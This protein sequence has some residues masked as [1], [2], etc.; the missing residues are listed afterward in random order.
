MIEMHL[1]G[2]VFLSTGDKQNKSKQKK[3][4]EKQLL[5]HSY[6][7][8]TFSKNFCSLYPI[9]KKDNQ[10][11]LLALKYLKKLIYHKSMFALFSHCLP[12]EKGNVEWVCSCLKL[13]YF[14]FPCLSLWHFI[15]AMHWRKMALN[16]IVF[17]IR[18]HNLVII[19]STMERLLET[20]PP[21]C[22]GAQS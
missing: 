11:A 4:T 14:K 17:N 6:C 16:R 9:F 22:G 12:W 13:C 7:N 2:Q 3:K 19:A 20:S 15:S 1:D 5:H 10:W 18:S 8:T 21:S